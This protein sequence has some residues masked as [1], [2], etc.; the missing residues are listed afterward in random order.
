MTIESNLTKLQM[1]LMSY[2]IKSPHRRASSGLFAWNDPFQGYLWI[3]NE[4]I[5]L[6]WPK[7]V[8]C[9][10]LSCLKALFVVKYVNMKISGQEVYRWTSAKHLQT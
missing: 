7:H 6:S 8:S 1:V 10:A 2:V 4:G 5:F 3:V 9:F